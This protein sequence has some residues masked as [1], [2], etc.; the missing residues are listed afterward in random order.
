MNVILQY[1]ANFGFVK[2]KA[3]ELAELKRENQKL[4]E[5]IEKSKDTLS[6]RVCFEYFG[7]SKVTNFVNLH[8]VQSIF[9]FAL[10]H[11]ATSTAKNASKGSPEILT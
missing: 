5:E 3:E 10:F 7:L 9:S 4:K 1:L 11:A 6:C 8:I 2:T